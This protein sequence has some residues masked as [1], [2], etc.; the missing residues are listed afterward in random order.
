MGNMACIVV[1]ARWIHRSCEDLSGELYE[2]L[3][4]CEG[5][6][7][8]CMMGKKEVL[9]IREEAKRTRVRK[10]KLSNADRS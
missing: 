9:V 1:C 3:K 7:R 10:R 2:G 4:E 8:F 5:E 6:L